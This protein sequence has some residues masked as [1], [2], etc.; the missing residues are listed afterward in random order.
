MQASTFVLSQWSASQAPRLYVPQ[1]VNGVR[2]AVDPPTGQV[3]PAAD[4]GFIVPGTGSVA[5]GI[6][7]GGQ[8]GFTKYLQ[9]SPPLVWGP[10]VGIA[11]DPMGDQKFVVRTGARHLL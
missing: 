10:R 11:W 6:A 4:I 2:S 8:N 1:M 7:Q 5:N 3:L 9:N